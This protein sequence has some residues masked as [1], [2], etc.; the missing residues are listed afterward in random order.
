MTGKLLP[1]WT[2]AQRTAFRKTPV[3]FDHNLAG[4]GLF[5]GE[6][7][8]GLLDTFPAELYDI[9]L[10]DY[11]ADHQLS[12]RVGERGG[13]TGRQLLEYLKQGRLWLQL[14]KVEEHASAL[15]ALMQAAF[16][17]MREQVPGFRPS[18]VTG[19]LIV[20]APNSQVPYHAD[21]PGVVLF[22]LAGRKRI[23]IYPPDE[24]HLPQAAMERIVMKQ[25]T[26][27]LAYRREFD[28]DAVA[29]DLEP[30]TAVVIPPHAPHRVDNL[31]GHNV[32]LSCNYHTWPDRLTN[33]AHFTNGVLRRRGMRIA[34][35]ARTPMPARAGL[36]AAST[37][38][39]RMGVVEDRL[40]SMERSFEIGSEDQGG[41]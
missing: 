4:S 6:A 25:Q 12:L 8:A 2:E 30:G 20:S 23:F 38:L 40:K 35:M 15:G 39:K 16:S 32:S 5:E 27:D 26:E 19:H 33:G 9:N 7:L 24:T 31:D 13:L 1:D 36:W 14:R 22:H 18:R 21:A 29:V 37:L 28:A 11:D 3:R 41:R 34:S 10:F 17:E